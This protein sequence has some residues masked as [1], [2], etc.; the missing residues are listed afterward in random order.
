MDRTTVVVAA[1]AGA[2]VC[3]GVYVL[4]GPENFFRP[5]GVL[6][7]LKTLWNCFYVVLIGIVACSGLS[8]LGNTCFM[9]AVLQVKEKA[10]AWGIYTR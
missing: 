1:C 3:A 5:K 8:N 9:N 6:A 7:T 4:W 2:A 10:K